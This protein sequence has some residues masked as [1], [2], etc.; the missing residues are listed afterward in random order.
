MEFFFCCLARNCQTV[1]LSKCQNVNKGHFEALILQLLHVVEPFVVA[2]AGDEFV[3]L[4]VL[5]NLA[6][7]GM[8]MIVVT[9]EMHC[10]S[11]SK[12]SYI[13]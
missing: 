4:A 2:A 8:T 1:K 9:H 10:V 3:V 13:Q 7:D 12:S 11:L 6:R 5:H